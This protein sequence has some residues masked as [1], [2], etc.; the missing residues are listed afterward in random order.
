MAEEDV[1]FRTP[2]RGEGPACQQS[3]APATVAATET[4]LASMGSL[5][6]ERGYLI[7][8]CA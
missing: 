4:S 6:E 2:P 3:S 7:S 5:Q 1:C 8:F